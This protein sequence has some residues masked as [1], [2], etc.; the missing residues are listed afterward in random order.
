VVY[1]DI[2]VRPGEAYSLDGR[3]NVPANTGSFRASVQLVV[4]NTWGGTLSTVTARSQTTATSGWVTT[5]GSVTIPNGGTTL[6]VQFKGE[7][8]RSEVYLDAL[9]LTRTR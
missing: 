5:P 8:L 1:Q 6:R 2:P 4:L 7:F 3:L 9:S